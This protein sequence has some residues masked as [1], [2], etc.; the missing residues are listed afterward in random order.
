MECVKTTVLWERSPSG[1]K[2]LN[3]NSQLIASIDV[4]KIDQQLL[5]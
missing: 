5:L 4:Q 3:I 2:R 1:Y